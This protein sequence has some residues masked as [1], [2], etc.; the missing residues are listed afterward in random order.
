MEDDMK[1]SRS[2][3]SCPARRP[4]TE[5][6]EAL[7]RRIVELE[8]VVAA[9]GVLSSLREDQP[10]QRE[11][12]SSLTAAAVHTSAH[13]CRPGDEWMWANLFIR[14]T[15]P[16]IEGTW[17]VVRQALLT[18]L[19]ELCVALRGEASGQTDVQPY[20]RLGQAN[21]EQLQLPLPERRPGWPR[22][23]RSRLRALKAAD[24]RRLRDAIKRIIA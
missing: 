14:L 11:Q 10:L 16:A 1:A 15:D 23:L 5:R 21:L 12:V 4:W 24:R 8:V 17:D 7:E 6:H 9:L 3:A 20:L 19:R 22:R 13:G 18:A 2:R